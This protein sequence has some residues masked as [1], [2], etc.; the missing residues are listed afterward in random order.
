[1]FALGNE[2]ED[3]QE[4]DCGCRHREHEDDQSAR[5][6]V[7]EVE[8]EIPFLQEAVVCFQEIAEKAGLLYGVIHSSSCGQ[9]AEGPR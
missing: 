1:M 5:A 8:A 7:V 6:A 9:S 3:R 2:V 4:E